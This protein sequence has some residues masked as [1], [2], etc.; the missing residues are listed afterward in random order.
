[1]L[2]LQAAW[3]YFFPSQ[4]SNQSRPTLSGAIGRAVEGNQRRVQQ[5]NALCC[6][7]LE[8]WQWWR[9]PQKGVDKPNCL[10]QHYFARDQVQSNV[11]WIC[12][13]QWGELGWGGSGVRWDGGDLCQKEMRVRMSVGCVPFITSPRKDL[14][15]KSVVFNISYNDCFRNQHLK[16]VYFLHRYDR[17]HQTLL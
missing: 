1:M 11:L 4:V 5:S 13:L 2:I 10:F 16:N 7:N 6:L 3:D 15:K 9:R 8:P 17:K 12:S 14:N